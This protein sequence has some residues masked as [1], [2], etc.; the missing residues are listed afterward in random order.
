M[1]R[2][3]GRRASANVDKEFVCLEK[4]VADANPARVGKARLAFNN[5][6]VLGL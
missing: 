6:Q 5:G 3:E 4:F 1:P 2:N